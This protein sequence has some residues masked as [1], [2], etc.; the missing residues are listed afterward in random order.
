MDDT[1]LKQARQLNLRNRLIGGPFPPIILLTDQSRQPDPLAAI[2]RLPRNSM[3]IFRQ[4][5]HPGRAALAAKI[6]AECHRLGHQILI[7]NDLSLALK[8]GADGLHLPEYRILQKPAI[9]GHIPAGLIVTSACHSMA[10]LRKLCL[11]PA[12]FRPDGVLISPVFPTQSHP[13]APN[14]A[15]GVVQRAARLSAQHNMTPIGLGGIDRNTIGK[16]RRSVLASVAGIG[17]SVR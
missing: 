8:L 12:R 16:L 17:F 3:V 15:F 11:L 7:A 2:A 4:Y 14:M 1:L 10:S 13:G 5:D 6:C 9:F